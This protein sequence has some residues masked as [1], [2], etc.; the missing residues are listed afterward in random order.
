[1]K[2]SFRFSY[3]MCIGVLPVCLRHVW[4]PQRPDGGASSPRTRVKMVVSLHLQM[5]VVGMDP[6]P[7]HV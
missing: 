4:C 1:M 5:E 3:L 2:L 7:L 6:G